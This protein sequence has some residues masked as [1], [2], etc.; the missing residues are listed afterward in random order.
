M[1]QYE[2]VMCE[3]GSPTRNNN[4]KIG[5]GSA[6]TV[7]VAHDLRMVAEASLGMPGK[8][9]TTATR[10]NGKWLKGPKVPMNQMQKGSV[11][12][13]RGSTA[14]G[15]HQHHNNQTAHTK[16]RCAQSIKLCSR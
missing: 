16:A 4:D 2:Q 6:G 9:A 8:E 11:G 5:E 7:R 13:Q 10:S 3:A 1:P 14:Q 15:K 12:V